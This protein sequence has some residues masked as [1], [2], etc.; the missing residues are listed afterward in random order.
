[1]NA[2]EFIVLFNSTELYDGNGIEVHGNIE[3]D[4]SNYVS[5]QH[6]ISNVVFNGSFIFKN[7]EIRQ[8]ISF[9]NCKF[10][11]VVNLN[12]L[13][14]L[15]SESNECFKLSFWGGELTNL[16]IGHCKNINE[17]SIDSI[18]RID[19]INI[20]NCDNIGT[21]FIA[22]NKSIKSL[23][24]NDNKA[25][26]GIFIGNNES[27]SRYN[28]NSTQCSQLTIIKNLLEDYIE[29]DKIGANTFELNHNV[30]NNIR[31]NGNMQLNRFDIIDN[32]TKGYLSVK[33][34]DNSEIKQITTSLGEYGQEFSITGKSKEHYIGLISLFS[35]GKTLGPYNFFNLNAG[36]LIISGL[37]QDLF[38]NVKDLKLN[39]FEFRNFIN[40]GVVSVSNVS[41]VYGG[42]KEVE[43]VDSHLGDI[44]FRGVDFSMCDKFT[45]TSSSLINIKAIQTI[46]FSDKVLNRSVLFGINLNMENR[47]VYRQLKQAMYSQGDTIQALKFKSLEMVEYHEQ[48]KLEQPLREISSFKEFGDRFSI[49]LNRFSNQNGLDWT[50][51][52]GLILV[53]TLITYVIIVL[54]VDPE[55]PV[56]Y[57]CSCEQLT[58]KLKLFSANLII[59]FR[60]MDPTLKLNEVLDKVEGIKEGRLITGVYFIYKIILAYL[61]FQTIAAFRK[62]LK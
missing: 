48:L 56:E 60:L 9:I 11:G 35:N 49:F 23:H 10:K 41:S 14:K 24:I 7:I 43:V 46:W 1:M 62:F 22:N 52:I 18:D 51:P 31:V 53:S 33:L 61:I 16:Y 30:T 8:E 40:K 55:L 6:R 59:F 37:I 42:L 2:S 54:N 27:G 36:R 12:S 25:K 45:I 26:G 13:G 21:I 32:N 34:E 20:H 4:S 44:E 39:H 17:I 5:M 15:T 38:I 29:I 47:E 50:R 28:I 3:I 57:I 19:Y 58:N